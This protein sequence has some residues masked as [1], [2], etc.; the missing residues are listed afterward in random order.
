ML[1]DSDRPD[2]GAQPAAPAAAPAASNA[3]VA[4]DLDVL[5]RQVYDILR[6]RLATEH[7]RM[8]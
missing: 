3:P 4:P 7:R 1:A 8:G 2:V 6:R 5:A